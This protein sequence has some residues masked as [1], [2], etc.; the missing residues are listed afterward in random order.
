[1]NPLPGKRFASAVSVVAMA[2]CVLSLSVHVVTLL[3]LYSKA[4]FNVQI[5]LFLGVFGMAFFAILAQERLMSEFSFFDRLRTLNPKFSF[6][7][8]R[9]LLANAPRWLR[10]SSIA[11]F[12]YAA[13]RFVVFASYSLPARLLS[14]PEELQ[15]FSAFAAAAYSFVAMMLMSYGRTER[16]LRPKEF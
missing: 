5:G 12:A 4:I 9:A 6:K 16:P 2:G 13:T 14:K 1:M 8:T 15:L 3:G 11:L 10:V 7:V